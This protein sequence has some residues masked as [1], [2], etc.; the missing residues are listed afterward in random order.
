MKAK[1]SP[2]FLVIALLI[3]LNHDPMKLFYQA[4]DKVNASGFISYGYETFWPDPMGT[5]DTLAGT[6]T[7]SRNNNQYFSYDYVAT[8]KNYDFIFLDDQFTRIEHQD[9]VVFLYSEEEVEKNKSLIQR[10]IF[11]TNSPLTLL[12]KPGWGY[13]QDTIIHGKVFSDFRLI[14]MDTTINEKKIFVELHLFV[15]V[16]KVVPARYERR[17]FLNGKSS[18]IIV[19]DYL[20]FSLEPEKRQLTPRPPS[21][22]TSRMNSD[23][24]KLI[25]LREGVVAPNFSATD[26]DGAPVDLKSLRGKKVLLNFSVI[27]CGYCKL[28]LDHLNRE[29]DRLSGKVAGI[30]INPEDSR[31]RVSGYRDKIGISFQV[32]PEGETIA[33][34][35]GV[36]AYPTFFL[37]DENGIIEKVVVG[38][39]SEFLESIIP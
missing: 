12:N 17:A 16:K 30:Y 9:S 29:V 28:A 13:K 39:R 34:E 8:S 35:Y 20:G 36:S 11:V 21:G 15:D 31:T 24:Q 26:L 5:I 3:A 33:R 22:Y 18:Q 10:N 7:F 2:P 38:Y 37:I 14:E 27:N 32:I 25:L 4:R 19:T 1:A 6:C 23:H